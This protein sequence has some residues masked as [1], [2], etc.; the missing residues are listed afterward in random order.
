MMKWRGIY[1][2]H[3]STLFLAHMKLISIIFLQIFLAFLAYVHFLLYLRTSALAFADS[4]VTPKSQF[5][6]SYVRTMRYILQFARNYLQ[7]W[8]AL[9]HP[10]STTSL[11][12]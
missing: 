4:R 12:S 2:K 1:G 9:C 5:P 3:I 6:R 8:F 7:K 11:S 10:L